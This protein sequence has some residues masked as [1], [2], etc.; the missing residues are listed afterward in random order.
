M[1]KDIHNPNSKFFM[2]TDDDMILSNDEYYDYTEDKWHRVDVNHVGDL[3]KGPY[4]YDHF[5][6]IRRPNPDFS[7]PRDPWI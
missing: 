7:Y 3:Y 1:I 6:V 4:G 2:L 5:L